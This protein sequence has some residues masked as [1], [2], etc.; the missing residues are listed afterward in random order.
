ML[1][2]IMLASVYLALSQ[3]VNIAHAHIKLGRINN[4]QNTQ[5]LC[6]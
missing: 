3:A 1:F 5:E 2:E 6:V 4:Y